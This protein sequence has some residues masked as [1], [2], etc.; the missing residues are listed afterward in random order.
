VLT[1]DATVNNVS[2]AE[3][4]ADVLGEVPVPTVE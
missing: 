3:V 4:V 2:K 1:P